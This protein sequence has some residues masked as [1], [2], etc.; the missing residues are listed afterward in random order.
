MKPSS[1]S[2]TPWSQDRK[3]AETLRKTDIGKAAIDRAAE[4]PK[5]NLKTQDRGFPDID[6]IESSSQFPVFT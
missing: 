1:A 4:S 5:N 3:L 6:L 2:S